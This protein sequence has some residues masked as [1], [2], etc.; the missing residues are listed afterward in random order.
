MPLTERDPDAPVG[1]QPI[2][3]DEV[4]PVRVEIPSIDVDSV[5]EDLAR[6]ENGI[7]Q[8]PVPE[9]AGWFTGGTVPGE[10]GP[11]VI[12]GH[13]DSGVAGAVFR[14]LDELEPGAEVLVEMSDGE[15]LTFRVDRA[16]V[17]GQAQAQF[18]SVEVYGPVPDRQLRL[19]TCH[20]FDP[21]NRRYVDNLVVFA[22]AVDS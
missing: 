15:T 2:P 18:P 13:V 17:F 20:S 3:D 7:L 10:R 14:D 22:T 1:P 19:I 5:L 12:A 21:D 4:V 16:E 9:Q 6:D 11:A 8:P